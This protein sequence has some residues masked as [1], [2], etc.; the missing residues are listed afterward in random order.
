MVGLIPRILYEDNHLLVVEKPA[1]IPVQADSSGDEDLLSILKAYIKEKYNKPGDVYLG[2]CHRLDRP[3]GGVMV[4][5]RTSKA[6]ERLTA[7][8]ASRQA[9]KRYAAVVEGASPVHAALSDYIRE[10]D[11]VRR[12]E[13]LSSPAPDAKPATLSFDTLARAGGHALLDIDLRTGRKHQ[14]RAQLAHHGWPIRFDQRYNPHPTPGQIALWA[15]S[16]SFEHPTKKERVSFYSA[17]QGE[18]FAPFSTQLA[19]LP[20]Y[21]Y[22]AAVYA[23]AQLLVVAKRAGVEVSAADAG[24]ASLQ[25]LLTPYFGPVTPCHRLDANTE[26]LVLFARTEEAEAALLA[27]FR[28][29]RV[30]KTYHALVLG[31]ME[32]R[33]ATLSAWAVKDA[34]QGLLRVYAAPSEGAL[35]IQTGYRVLAEAEG[36]SF[37]EIRLYTGRT[38]QIRAHLAYLGHPVLGDDK[39]GDR[40][41]NRAFGRKRQALLCFRL[42]LNEPPGSPLAY[43]NGRVFECPWDIGMD[44][45]E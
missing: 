34:E 12:A 5:A 2:L 29:G 26:G 1:N 15:Y 31:R 41:T 22:C 21:E 43:L 35:P 4:F 10:T 30:D 20:L 9:H 28:E 27:A 42:A 33:E 17:P 45:K 11:S 7:Q 32:Q 19:A 3:V 37:L 36:Y 18:A 8:F 23:D 38:H 14:I 16:L 44:E 39:Y 24:E 13:V 40:A 25:A 6:A